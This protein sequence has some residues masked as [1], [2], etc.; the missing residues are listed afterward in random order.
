MHDELDGDVRE[1]E[2]MKAVAKEFPID[3]VKSFF[4]I[5]LKSYITLLTFGSPYEMNY[6]LQKQ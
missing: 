4:Q 6:F 5:K 1:L 3:I 2:I